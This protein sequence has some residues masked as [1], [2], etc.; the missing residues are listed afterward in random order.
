M[1]VQILADVSVALRAVLERSVVASVGFFANET[2]LEQYIDAAG[3]F[4]ADRNDVSVWELVCFLLVDVRRT[5]ELCVV[6]RARAAQF[7][8][9]ITTVSLSVVAVEDYPRSVRFFIKYSEG[10]RPGQPENGMMQSMT[11]FVDGHCVRVRRASRSV[12][13]VIPIRDGTVLNGILQCQDKALALRLV[14][15]K[16]TTHLFPALGWQPP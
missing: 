12:L 11:F 15:N 8:F 9:D 7:H 3:T 14:N 2:W 6:I 5:F 10:S 1:N 13:Q 4:S 16:T